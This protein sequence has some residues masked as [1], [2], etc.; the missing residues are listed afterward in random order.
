MIVDFFDPQSIAAW[1][2]TAPSR[3]GPQ[4]AA[5]AKIQPKYA[6]AIKAAGDLLRAKR[7]QVETAAV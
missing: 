5:M 7:R 2:A 3:H 6:S 1:Y 4:L